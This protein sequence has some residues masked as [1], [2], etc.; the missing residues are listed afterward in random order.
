MSLSR[1][2]LMMGQTC[3]RFGGSNSI[4][5]RS[6]LGDINSAAI[7][8]GHKPFVQEWTPVSV[9]GVACVSNQYAPYLDVRKSKRARWENP[10]AYCLDGLLLREFFLTA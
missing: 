1:N 9:R 7:R 4:D 10:L 5:A 8:A 2:L 3:S 6:P